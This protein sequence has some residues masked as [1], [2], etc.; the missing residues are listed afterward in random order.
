MKRV[1]IFVLILMMIIPVQAFGDVLPQELPKK[2]KSING[3]FEIAAEIDNQWIKLGELGFGKF[4]ETKEIDCGDYLKGED[5]LI[6]IT[7]NGGGAS[8]LD[9]VFLDGV[10]AVKA[11]GSEGKVLSKLSK[12]DLDV[13]PVEDGITLE[14]KVSGNNGI[15]S[16]TGRI[17]PVD[18]SKE[19][20][21][22]PLLN[23]PKNKDDIKEFYTYEINSN[24]GTVIA[25]GNIEEIKGKDPLV[26]EFRKTGSGHPFGYVY[27]WVM[28]DEENLYVTMDV[29][30]DNT[31]D[32]DKDYGKVYINT[33]EGIKEYKV[34][35]PET[36]WGNTSFTYTDK[37]PY[38]HKVYEFKIPLSELG[39]QDEIEI[40]F[41]VYGTAVARNMYTL[42]I[43]I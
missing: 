22:F 6:R 31:Y 13:T 35:V 25:D 9:A 18:I 40:A 7:Q 29:T 41:A 16:V 15:L 12:E 5:A 4:Q 17:E 1:F 28:N 32:G 27:F 38:E 34:S 23:T 3:V 37:V 30:V 24:F 36:K 20:L 26:E 39:N 19:P 11:N 2:E 33:S 43:R 10:Q 14:F 8:Y 42:K 21:Q